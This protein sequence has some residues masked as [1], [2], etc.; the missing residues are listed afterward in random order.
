MNIK[1]LAKEYDIKGDINPFVERIVDECIF[2]FLCSYD[3]KI[4][5]LVVKELLTEHL[6]LN[7]NEFYYDENENLK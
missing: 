1:T 4:N 3:G 2:A 5:P 7:D 6:N